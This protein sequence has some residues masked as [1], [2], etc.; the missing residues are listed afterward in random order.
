MTHS[1]LRSLWL[2][3]SYALLILL[4]YFLSPGS[5]AVFIYQGF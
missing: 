2:S 1:P 4:V 5:S 3:L